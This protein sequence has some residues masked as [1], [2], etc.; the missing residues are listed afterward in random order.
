[1]ART[2]LQIQKEMQKLEREAEQLKASEVAGVVERIKTAIDFYGLK[3]SD[4]FGSKTKGIVQG[5]RGPRI[6]VKA[7]KVP[8]PAK[9]RD[10][11]TGKTWTGH[12]MRPGWFRSAVEGGMKPEDMGI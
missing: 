6:Q 7:R 3:A 5:K 4:L 2:L 12:G 9:Y 1:M 10:K 11:E 8:S